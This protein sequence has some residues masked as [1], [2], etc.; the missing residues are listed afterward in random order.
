MLVRVA[1]V[2]LAVV[3]LAGPIVLT[4]ARI[5]AWNSRT[6]RAVVVDTSDS[7]RVPDG[8]GV[9]PESAAA[10]AAAA[11]LRTATYGR[12]ID[13]RDLRE[14]LAR[15]SAWLA[16][17][18]PARREIVVISDLQR[19]A[20]SRSRLGIPEGTGLRFIPI[21]RRAESSRFE[22]TRLLGAGDVVPREQTIEATAD[23]TAVV[24]QSRAGAEGAGLRLIVPPGAEQSLARLRRALAVAGTPAASPDQPITIQ[25]AGA[26]STGCSSAD[27]AWMDAADDSAIARPFDSTVG[28][29]S[30][31]RQ[32][33]SWQAVAQR[34]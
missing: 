14:G 13:A 28:Q 18:P 3:A 33:R 25:F 27:S 16:A 10:E 20:L 30:A 15:A 8:S 29:L 23:T 21:G 24:V 1:I 11:E 34:R 19:G 5:A 32:T 7:M 6:A 4:E 2:A 31:G 22:G 26:A 17:S 9:A 12:R